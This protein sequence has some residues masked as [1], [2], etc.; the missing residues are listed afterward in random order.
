MKSQSAVFGAIALALLFGV[1]VRIGGGSAIAQPPAP[2]PKTEGKAP[3]VALFIP[4]YFYPAGRGAEAW[5]KLGEAAKR[6]PIIAIANVDSGPGAPDSPTDPLYVKTIKAASAANVTVIAYI[7]TRYGKQPIAE[8]KRDI[9]RWVRDHPSIRGFFLDELPSD[10]AKVDWY[11]EI[12]D[13]GRSKLANARI[14]GNPGTTC[15]EAYLA[16]NA[17]DS[18]CLYENLRGFER[19]TA[20]SWA[21]RHPARRFAVLPHSIPDA[22]GMTRAVRRAVEQRAGLIYVTDDR[23]PNPWDRLPSYWDALVRETA[24]INASAR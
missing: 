23:M 17:V 2:E 13:Y 7:S 10:A 3:T 8:I 19:W 6:V 21:S 4:A 1:G 22:D 18:V 20:P 14:I 5:T 11:R 16:R 15:D 12:A 24:R 9:D